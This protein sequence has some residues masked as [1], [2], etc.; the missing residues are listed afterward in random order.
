[1]ATCR[2]I[3]NIIGS[4]LSKF[5]IKELKKEQRQL[6]DYLLRGEDCVAVL[7]TGYGKSLP[8][9]IFAPI[10]HQQG[11]EKAVVLVCC[12]LIALMEDKVQRIQKIQFVSAEYIG[13]KADFDLKAHNIDV[14]FASPE[15][16]VG[17]ETCRE[18]IQSLNVKVIVID[19]FHT[20]A[21]CSYVGI[22]CNLYTKNEEDFESV[23]HDR[24]S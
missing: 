14:V 24:M 5:N 13:S 9:Q 17:S 3:E 6:L 2:D 21:T 7:P 12:P 20:I 8:Y 10:Y 15:L 4:V 19:E 11:D 23:E 22:K 1:M 16:L 18:A